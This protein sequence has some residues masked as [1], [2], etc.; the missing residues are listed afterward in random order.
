MPERGI[1]ITRGSKPTAGIHSHTGIEVS[2]SGKPVSGAVPE[3]MELEV[4]CASTGSGFRVVLEERRVHQ[5]SRYKVVGT[6]REEA[7]RHASSNT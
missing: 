4:R 5:T 7:S 1:E 3:S 2:H 6:L